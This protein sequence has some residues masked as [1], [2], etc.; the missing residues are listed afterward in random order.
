MCVCACVC[1][2]LLVCSFNEKK[3]ERK[4]FQACVSG[5]RKRLD[6]KVGIKGFSNSQKHNE[7]QATVR[8]YAC[9]YG[10]YCVCIA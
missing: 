8:V 6:L 9:K 3:K 10:F 1:A 2:L 7:V 4:K 5:E